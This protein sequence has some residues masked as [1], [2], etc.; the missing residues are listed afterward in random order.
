MATE[1]TLLVS[2]DG[3][4]VMRSHDEGKT[5]HRIGINQDLEYD[6][7]VR[8]LLADPRDPEWVFA[9]AERGLFHSEDCGV[10]WTRIDGALNDMA[11]WKLAIAPSDPNIMYAGTGSPTPSIFHR[12]TDGGR[13]WERTSL[14][15]PAKCAGVSRPRMLALAVDPD[16]ARDVWAGVEEG[17]LFHST[18]GGDHWERLDTHWPQER[19][20]SDIH[21]IIV[22][23][24]TPKVVLALVVNALYRSE[25]GGRTW[26][27]AGA[28]DSWGMRYSRFL[29]KKANSDELFLGIGDGTPGTI[30]ALL[31][32]TDKGASFQPIDLPVRPN[33]CLWAAGGHAAD[34][35][36]LLIGTKFGDLFSSRDGGRT[37]EKEWR[38]FNEIT[39]IT[40][41]PRVPADQ[42]SVHVHA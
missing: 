3:Q 35:D 38:E 7:R 11:V 4:A 10:T 12:S 28:Q 17:G 24:G 29:L 36:F 15:M 37:W 19:G 27:R 40:W 39:D 9:G 21:N 13:T 8:C 34:P 30:G 33:S 16:N 22:L 18:D 26:S 31:R 2:T 14:E 42:G 20:N 32:S 6:D 5:W 23:P 41:L 1:K 25:D